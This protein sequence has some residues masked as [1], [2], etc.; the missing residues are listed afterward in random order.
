MWNTTTLNK[1]QAE[2]TQ[3]NCTVKQNYGNFNYH[4]W[5][6]NHI[7]VRMKRGKEELSSI[8]HK[9]LNISRKENKK[10]APL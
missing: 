9:N 2:N 1:C 6:S 4:W 3:F 10:T 8:R 5:S 7:H